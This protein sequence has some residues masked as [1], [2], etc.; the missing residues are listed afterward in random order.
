MEVLWRRVFCGAEAEDATRITADENG[1][2]GRPPSEHDCSMVHNSTAFL[3]FPAA[4]SLQFIYFR[5]KVYTDS[6]E[7]P[8]LAQKNEY[9]LRMSEM[10]SIKP[11][12]LYTHGDTPK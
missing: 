10:S 8:I 1:L 7:A 11:L 5:L 9:L 12:I 2:E 3:S 4:D 6:T